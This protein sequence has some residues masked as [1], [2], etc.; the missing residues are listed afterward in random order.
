MIC[1]FTRHGCHIIE[2]LPWLDKLHI[3]STVHEGASQ[4]WV[5]HP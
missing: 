4:L 5:Q 1:A 3:V 2:P